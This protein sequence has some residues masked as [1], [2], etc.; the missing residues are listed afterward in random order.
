[1]QVECCGTCEKLMI[2]K[3]NEEA[4]IFCTKYKQE[5]EIFDRPCSEYKEYTDAEEYIYSKLMSI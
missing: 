4:D 1:M 3:N 5:V 2:V